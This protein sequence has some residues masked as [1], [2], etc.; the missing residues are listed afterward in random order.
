[1]KFCLIS[2]GVCSNFP[3]FLG[4]FIRERYN[5]IVRG[6]SR[7]S[8]VP[9][10]YSLPRAW[11]LEPILTSIALLHLPPLLPRDHSLVST[12]Q[13]ML[14]GETKIIL[15]EELNLSKNVFSSFQWLEKLF[16]Y[17][18]MCQNNHTK[19]SKKCVA[20]IHNYF[21]PLIPIGSKL[22]NV[23]NSLFLRNL[24]Q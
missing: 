18:L 2:F 19:Y 1:M 22:T 14:I 17:L 20:I 6:P 3:S 7:S 5:C 24:F 4:S 9:V 10:L 16:H 8:W 12:S 23:Q 11:F 13:S 15:M 21:Q